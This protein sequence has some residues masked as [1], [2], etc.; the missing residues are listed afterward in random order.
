[1]TLSSRASAGAGRGTMAALQEVRQADVFGVLKL[2][3]RSRWI[4]LRQR[5]RHV[6][7]DTRDREQVP[8]RERRAEPVRACC[9]QHALH[10]GIDRGARAAARR[11]GA[12]DVHARGVEAGDDPDGRFMA[13]IGSGL[14]R[15]IARVLW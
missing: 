10:G 12:L 11:R 3:L 4:C 2:S 1:M 14:N 15:R 6:G 8:G 7:G 5:P 13:V 9:Q